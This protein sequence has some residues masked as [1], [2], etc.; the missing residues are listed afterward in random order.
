MRKPQQPTQTLAQR[1]HFNLLQTAPQ[2]AFAY[3]LETQRDIAD[4]ETVVGGLPR[5]V[6]KQPFGL[7]GPGGGFGG[8]QCRIDQL[9]MRYLLLQKRLKQRIVGAANT[10][11]STSSA[12]SGFKYSRAVR[13]VTS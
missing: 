4:V 7:Q 11:V 1:H 12:N 2:K 3:G 10:S 9:Q 8:G 5:T 13:R 6:V